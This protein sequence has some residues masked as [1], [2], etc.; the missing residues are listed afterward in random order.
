M[1][2][3]KSGVEKHRFVLGGMTGSLMPSQHLSGSELGDGLGAL[4]N[5]VLGELSG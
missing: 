5:S 2:Q 1:C 4:G 3:F